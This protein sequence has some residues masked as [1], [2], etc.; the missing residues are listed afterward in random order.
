M[1]EVHDAR[2]DRIIEVVDNWRETNKTPC[3]NYGT[4]ETAK[5]AAITG[6]ERYGKYFCTNKNPLKYAIIFVPSWGR[7][8]VGYDLTEAMGRKTF[9]GGYIG[10]PNNEGFFTY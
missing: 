4:V 2:F 1:A 3:K 8:V 7:Y 5:R 10:A 9:M 6:A